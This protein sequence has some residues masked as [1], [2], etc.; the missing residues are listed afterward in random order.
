MAIDE[1]N[2]SGRRPG[3]KID[4]VLYDSAPATAGQYDRRR[5]DNTKKLI[6]DPL[7]W[8]FGPMNSGEGKAMTPIL[9]EAT[10]PPSA[11]STNPD[12]TNP[13]W[14]RSSTKG[15]RSISAP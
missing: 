1:A 3:Y 14:R 11:S 13:P 15:K 5:R 7:W 4:V 6:A 8:C 9:S 12:I 10:L 2:E